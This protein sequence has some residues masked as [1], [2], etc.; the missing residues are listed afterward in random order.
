MDAPRNEVRSGGGRGGGPRVR[1]GGVRGNRQGPDSSASR[2]PTSV[3]P[4]TTTAAGSGTTANATSPDLAAVRLKLTAVARNL[5]R[6]VALAVRNGD[7]ALYIAEQTGRIVT[8]SSG[9]TGPVPVLDIHDEVSDGNEQGLLGITFSPDG[10]VCY[11]DFTDTKGNTH[12]Q[13]L[14]MRGRVA[15]KAQRRELLEVNQPYSNHNGGELTIGPD[16]MLYIGLGDGGSAGDPHGNGQNLGTLLAKI[17]RINPA[18]SGSA[19]YSVPSDNPYVDDRD[20]RPET[21]MWGLRNPW[22]FSFDRSTGD[23]WIGDVGQNAF[24]EIDE[25]PAGASGINWG[26]SQREGD[27]DYKGA[28][29]PGA[30]D[31]IIERSHQEGFCAIVGGYVYRGRAIP[32]LDGAYLYS[33]NCLGKVFGAVQRNGSIVETRDLGIKAN[34]VT[35]FGEDAN[36]EL[37]VLDLGG[38][39]SRI[40]VRR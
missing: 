34:G 19:A 11:I 9:T 26:W 3:V 38:T 10:S 21:W 15:Q 1:C 20:A 30:R 6:P 13:A 31:P 12:V 27:H 29:P 28:E 36:G 24:E 37:Y 8:V 4:T 35:S 40:D 16:G 17:L 32:E 5:N 22:R 18:A 39:V 33:D 25:A 23:V 7:G 14:P 2:P